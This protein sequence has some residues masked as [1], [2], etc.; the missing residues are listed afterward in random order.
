MRKS[1]T[2][3]RI[4]QLCWLLTIILIILLYNII[5]SKN[6]L[7]KQ[8]AVTISENCTVELNDDIYKNVD[9][10]QF[11]F[12]FM[13]RGDTVK[14]TLHLPQTPIEQPMMLL[15][16]NFS[17][18]T[19]N[20]DGKCIYTYGQNYCKNNE[21]TGYGYNFVVIPNQYYGKELKIIFN[22]CEDNA[23][24]KIDP[25]ILQSA[26]SI[27]H[28]ILKGKIFATVLEVFIF[29][30]GISICC[31]LFFVWK[32]SNEDY[33]LLWISIFAILVSFWLLCYNRAI[34]VVVKNLNILSYL[35]YISF[36]FIPIP[37]LSY[38]YCINE[39]KRIRRITTGLLI[40]LCFFLA[41]AIALNELKVTHLQSLLVLFHAL[42]ILSVSYLIITLIIQKLRYKD[43][44]NW[45]VL[46]GFLTMSIFMLV[47]LILY[48]IVKYTGALKSA[49]LTDMVPAGVLIFIITLVMSAYYQ[50]K[51][52]S[53]ETA[54]KQAVMK[55]AY[56][57]ILT[58]IN[59]RARCEEKLK[60]LEKAQN[61][62][63]I[64]T[65]DLNNFKQINDTFGHRI[66]D[67]F[68]QQFANALGEVFSNHFYGRIGGDE[69]IIILET[70]DGMKI[71]EKMQALKQALLQQATQNDQDALTFAYGWA[72]RN[73]DFNSELSILELYDLADKNMYEN[74][75]QLKL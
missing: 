36:Y 47:N 32:G 22:V 48:N 61:P 35:E 72:V 65:I 6:P 53:Y 10:S 31:F 15:W 39:K 74:K 73:A 26:H 42:C 69:F 67:K 34:Q 63:V 68:L 44:S 54:E 19:V 24:Q 71:D 21:M 57:D 18:V 59:N 30:I 64:I 66:G 2:T 9:L 17:T 4:Y 23:F 50:W 37:I 51:K 25:I 58:G 5:V 29:Y 3:K 62:M 27:N 20:L 46:I 8:N 1:K 52:S 41:T 56:T 14:I 55:L 70:D 40:T 7:T 43:K 13:N 75:R 33:K 12:H 11:Q 38:F 49:S 16:S 28:E 60:E 45:I